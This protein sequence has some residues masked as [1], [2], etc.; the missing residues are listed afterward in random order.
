MLV[1]TR[2]LG[3]YLFIEKGGVL[4][5]VSP[6]EVNRNR[7]VRFFVGAPKGVIVQRRNHY[8]GMAEEISIDFGGGA[9]VHISPLNVNGRQIKVGAKAPDSIRIAREEIYNKPYEARK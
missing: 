9:V 8:Q 5:K 7:E 1:L 4:V 3:E 6:V 2:R